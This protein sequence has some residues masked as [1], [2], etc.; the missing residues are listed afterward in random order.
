MIRTA[1]P[2]ANYVRLAAALKPVKDALMKALR[3]SP[4]SFGRAFVVPD[5]DAVA[6]RTAIDAALP[7]LDFQATDPRR[8]IPPKLMVRLRNFRKMLTSMRDTPDGEALGALL[9]SMEGRTTDPW[10]KFLEYHDEA[11]ALVNAADEERLSAFDVGPYSVQPFN[12]GRGDW[13]DEK[14]NTLHYVLRESTKLLTAHGLGRYVGGAILVY[15]TKVLPPSVGKGMGSLAQYSVNQD[16]IWLTA[17]SGRQKTLLDFAHETGHRVY[18]RLIGNR[19]RAM[20]KSYFE[21]DT[22]TPDIDAVVRAW[23]SWA[24]APAQPDVTGDWERV[25]Y[26][27]HLAYWLRHLGD[28][29]QHDLLMWT[30][31]ISDKAGVDEKYD[32]MRGAPRRNQV[33]ALDTIISKK[34]EIRSFMTPV[35]SYSATNASELFAESFSHYIVD[36]PSRLHPKLRAELRRAVPA[37]KLASGGSL[38]L[39]PDYG[40][41][42][43]ALPRGE[44]EAGPSAYRVASRSL[45][46]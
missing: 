26:G 9:A 5:A 44:D 21:G 32:A 3:A 28:T 13:D 34:S 22:D 7:L 41:S 46:G 36:G 6:L 43:A 16:I 40:A 23:E 2:T 45:H 33:P 42:D 35:T 15:P 27:R 24:S 1:A 29:G 30:E 8:P 11:L 12:T 19:G 31:I 10:R 20:W 17:G 25:K 18:H 38:S 14:W 4:F 39:R 37:L